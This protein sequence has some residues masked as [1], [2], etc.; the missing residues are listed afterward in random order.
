MKNAITSIFMKEPQVLS[1]GKG[2]REK[3]GNVDIKC[4]LQLLHVYVLDRRCTKN[5][6]IAMIL[7]VLF[8]HGD[9]KRKRAKMKNLNTSIFAKGP[10]VTTA[11][12]RAREKSG[13]VHIKCTLP[14]HVYVLE[15]RCTKNP[16]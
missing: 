11:E 15:K 6:I 3:S 9:K 1:A 13:N 7:R 2:A 5:P 4:T 12:G 10:Q 8:S 14:L 16:I